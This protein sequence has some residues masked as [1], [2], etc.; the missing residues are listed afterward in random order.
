M[1]NILTILKEMG[2]EV[3]SDKESAL[4]TAVSENYKTIAE[5]Q[6]ALNKIT[7]LEN[8][9]ADLSG[10]LDTA[11]TTISGFDGSMS[12]ADVKKLKDDYEQQ[13]KEAQEAASKKISEMNQRSFIEKKFNEINVKQPAMREYYSQRIMSED[14][15]LKW[16]EKDN[17]F[18]GLDE[19][20]AKEN[21]TNHFYETAQ[22]KADREAREKAQGSVPNF[23]VPSQGKP[24]PANAPNPDASVFGFHFTPVRTEK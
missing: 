4:N 6:K 9:K 13:I 10:Q 11:N 3:P 23:T 1:K 21:E 24:N 16:N 14:S 19:W 8:E 5:H 18:Y 20:L 22:E 12:K 15:G 2:I 7:T 17:T